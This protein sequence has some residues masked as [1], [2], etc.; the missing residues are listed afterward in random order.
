MP[1]IHK[2]SLSAK[3][4]IVLFPQEH[5]PIEERNLKMKKE[6]EHLDC[7]IDLH[8]NNLVLAMADCKGKTVYAKRLKNELEHVLEELSG[9]EG[10]VDSVAVE[11]TYNWYWLVDGLLENDYGAK[12][13][14]T[15]KAN[16]RNTKKHTDDFD[17]ALHLCYLQRMNDL[18][19]GYI[20]P[21]SERM[22]RDLLR[23]RLLFMKQRT[24]QRLS[25]RC[26]F[27]RMTGR[28]HSV[29][30]ILSYDKDR[31]L[32]ILG[33]E[34]CVF[35]AQI[36][37]KTYQHLTKQIK[38]IEKRVLS[39]VKLKDEF[40]IL[41][42][43]P[44]VGPILAMTIMLEVG[45]IG[46]FAKCGNFVSYCRCAPSQRTSNNKKKG[47]NNRKNGNKYLCWAFVEAATTAK[48]CHK[49][50]Q[51]YYDRKRQKSGL[52]ILAAKAT[53]AKLC[54]SA[55]FVLRDQIPFDLEKA[56]C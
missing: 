11:S 33:D 40:K 30:K 9:F 44:G 55:F 29:E 32:E 6:R 38:A 26:M 49:P 12:L 5:K 54:K 22:V 41:Q 36:Q 13:V 27:A 19:T 35:T 1:D 39:A 37:M 31:L 48:R 50:I 14:N 2:R 18:P 16:S 10:R 43:I 20:Y 23:R 21:K 53:G 46:R 17:D 8:S 24:A 56:F 28:N 25:L 42:T 7:A 52:S 3:R 51:R 15:T 45:E 47:S 34:N 4:G